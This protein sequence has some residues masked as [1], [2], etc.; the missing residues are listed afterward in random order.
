M[1]KWELFRKFPF[2][3]FKLSTLCRQLDSREAFGEN[4]GPHGCLG[5]RSGGAAWQ[6]AGRGVGAAGGL[7]PS[8]SRL[9]PF[10]HRRKRLR[11]AMTGAGCR[12]RRPR[13]PG[14]LRWRGSAGGRGRPPLRR[15]WERRIAASASPPRNARGKR[16]THRSGSGPVRFIDWSAW[17]PGKQDQ[18][19]AMT[20]HSRSTSLGRRATSTQERAGK[21]SVKYW[22]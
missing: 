6:T 21:G 1:P 19:S 16:K 9:A 22:A 12:G 13:R 4:R 14:V 15:G 11:E 8:G 20:S 18:S 7:P 10:S 5:L 17:F 3:R 2:W